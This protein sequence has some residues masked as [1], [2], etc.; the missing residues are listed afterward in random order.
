[1]ALAYHEPVLCAE[2][3]QYLCTDPRGIYVD[4][5]LGGGGHTAQIL[6]QGSLRSVIGIDRDA[7]AISAAQQFLY[8]YG[9]R[10][11]YVQGNFASLHDHLQRLGIERVQGILMDLGVSSHQIDDRGRGFSFQTDTRLD[12]RMNRDQHLDG[13]MVVNTYDESR[14]ADLFWKYGEE[15]FSRV[16]ARRIVEQ[17]AL[18]TIDTTTRLAQ[19]VESVIGTPMLVKSLARIFQAI[20][21][22]VNNELD[23]LQQALKDSVPALEIGGRLVVISYHS[24][25]DRIVK[26]FIREQAHPDDPQ[27]RQVQR[28]STRQP[29]LRMITKKPVVATEEEINTNSRARSAKLRAAERI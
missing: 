8:N 18:S 22:E 9:D 26:Q 13:W 7:E 1:M 5:T 23:H 17:R 29:Q 3:L 15:R 27:T 11:T 21:I 12:M 24:L 20:R 6:Q 4:C 25:E 10:V 19:I 2:V 16:I 14:L 28:R